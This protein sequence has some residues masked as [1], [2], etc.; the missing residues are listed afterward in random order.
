MRAYIALLCWSTLTVR[1]LTLVVGFGL[2]VGSICATTLLPTGFM[3]D[4]D[5]SRV[6]VS[7]RAAARARRWRIR[8]ARPT[9]WSR[10]LHTIPEVKSVFVLGGT[11][12]RRAASRCARRR[13]SSSSCR[14]PS[15]SCRRSRS[16]SI[17]ADKLADI[18]DTR[19]WYVNER[20]ERELSFSMLSHSGEDLN[21][22]VRKLEGALRQVPGFEN[23]AADA[24]IDRPELRVVPKLDEAARAR[25]RAEQIAETI[26]VATI[27]DVDANLAKFNVG[28]RQVPIRVQ[29]DGERAHGTCSACENLRVTN[30]SRRRHSAHRRRRRSSSGEGPSSIRPLRPRAARRD[31]RRSRVALRH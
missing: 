30:A 16:R 11:H 22:A 7:R 21:D 23:V 25:R 3:P 14:R 12:A 24:A 6:V 28:D 18:P 2:F 26:R 9:R 10:S 27:G 15:A 17:I 13:C 31:R 1:Y 19:A 4:E 20:G 8:A 29:L 5:T